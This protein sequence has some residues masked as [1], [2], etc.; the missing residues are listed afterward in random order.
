[1]K[2]FF[3]SITAAEYALWGGSVL[4]IVLSFI[5]LHNTDYLNLAGSLIGATALILVAKGN[6]AGQILCV[7]FSVYYGFVS[8]F[9]HYY[10][11]MI[12]YLGMTAPI[13][14]AAVVGWLRHPF[15][16][17]RKEVEVNALRAR[18][19]PIILAA[20]GAVTAAFY[21]ILRALGTANLLWSTVSVTTSFTAMVLAQRR[22]PFYAAAY[23]LNDVVLIILWTLAAQND[24]EYYALVVCF[25]V[26]LANDLYGLFNWLRMQRRQTKIAQ[27]TKNRPPMS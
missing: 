12:T 13:A 2:D 11:E 7:V 4:A 5:L 6:I 24:A 25:G 20:A 26:F 23:A 18:E 8:Y 1:M 22:S 9:T 17:D 3:R 10:G 15:R 14:V 21:F 27:E 16:G 19:Y